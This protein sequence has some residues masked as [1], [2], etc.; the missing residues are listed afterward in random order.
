MR[1]R[2]LS[3]ATIQKGGGAL[4]PHISVSKEPTNTVPSSKMKIPSP[5]FLLSSQCPSYRA[6]VE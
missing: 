2:R 6:P 5:C 3:I 1:V 4:S